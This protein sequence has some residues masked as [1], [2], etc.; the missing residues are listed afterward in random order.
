M[1]SL[2]KL[3]LRELPEPLLMFDNFFPC[4]DLAK[5]IWPCYTVL[6]H[7]TGVAVGEGDAVA[8][9]PAMIERLP[10][11]YAIVL[12]FLWCDYRTMM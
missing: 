12:R 1:A 9:L 10:S 2:L 4:I 3:Y 11:S 8:L 5:R 7:S 6:A